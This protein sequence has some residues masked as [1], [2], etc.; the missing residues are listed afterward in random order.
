V[1]E[2][3][4]HWEGRTPPGTSF[5][6]NFSITLRNAEGLELCRYNIP[7]PKSE[8]GSL[9]F[10]GGINLGHIAAKTAGQGHASI[11]L[12]RLDGVFRELSGRK[13]VL[14]KHV[15]NYPKDGSLFSKAGYIRISPGTYRK[16]FGPKVR[17]IWEPGRKLPPEEQRIVDELIKFTTHNRE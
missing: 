7:Y 16:F 10:G 2:H 13:L 1:D 9:V 3:V 8:G 11:L 17:P 6:N 5:P 4:L 14:V 12:R 15:V